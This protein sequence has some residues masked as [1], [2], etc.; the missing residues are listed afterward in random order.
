MLLVRQPG[1]ERRLADRI[2][3]TV[4]FIGVALTVTT[5]NSHHSFY[6]TYV[7]TIEEGMVSVDGVIS[8]LRWSNPHP[9]IRVAVTTDNGETVNWLFEHSAINTLYRSG[10][11]EDTVSEGLVVTVSGF[12][13]RN[14]TRLARLR[15]LLVRHTDPESGARVFVGPEDLA[16]D[17][18]WRARLAEEGTACAGIRHCVDLDEGSLELLAGEFA[19]AGV[20]RGLGDLSE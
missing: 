1:F 4:L 17:D 8:G 6:G 20:F 18:T 19:S 9:I 3:K 10:W 5:A 13:A 12:R 16:E 15:S 2:L 7:P 14:G 11:V